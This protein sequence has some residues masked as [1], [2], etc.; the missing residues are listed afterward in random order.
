ME[1][2][3]FDKLD[4]KEL[5][6]GISVKVRIQPRASR[7]TVA[8][9]TDDSLKLCLT[10]PPVDG[11]ANEACINFLAQL[12]GVA[13]KQVG[14]ISGHKNRNKIVKIAGIDKKK[15]LAVFTNN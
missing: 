13:K 1:I 10:A 14:I 9:I 8:G 12:C 6:D 15:L 4:I 5:P 3:G 7:N 11:E 2:T